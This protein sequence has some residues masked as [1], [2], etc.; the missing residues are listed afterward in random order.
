MNRLKLFP[1]IFLYTL[2]LML[3]ISL[4]A[5]GMIY[6]LAPIIKTDI[7]LSKGTSGIVS[8]VSVPRNTEIT[9]AI[10]GSL[11]YSILI[12]FIV[13]LICAFFFSR[14]IINPIKHILGTTIYMESLV[15]SAA[16]NVQS[17]DEIGML[18][19]SIN[20]LYQKLLSTIDYLREEKDRVSEAEKQKVNF[21]RAASHELKTPVTSLNAMLENMIMEVGKYQ[22][23]EIYLPLCKEQTEQLG[24]MITEIL[25]TSRLGTSMDNEQSQTIDISECLF[26]LCSQYQLLAQTN[27]QIF[28]INLSDNFIACLPPKIFAKALSNILSNAVAYTESGKSIAV[29]THGRELIVENECVPIAEEHIKHIFEPFYRPDYARNRNIGGNGL[30]LYIVASILDNLG[31]PYSFMPMKKPLGM[32]FIINL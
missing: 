27:G 24:R 10:L 6:L 5:N 26:D 9:N 18:S 17:N 16:C 21:L 28:K 25:D 30:G 15:K 3:I 14:A 23:H 12:C 11:P 13:S 31:Y 19:K 4:L 7:I 2:T 1:K 22:N 8:S 32:R 20:K 29:Y